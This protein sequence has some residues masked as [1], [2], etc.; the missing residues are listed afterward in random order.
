MT[1]NPIMRADIVLESKSAYPTIL[2]LKIDS[3]IPKTR[4]EG[5]ALTQK[6]KSSEASFFDILFCSVRDFKVNAPTGYPPVKDKKNAVNTGLNLF[7]IPQFDIK[8][9]IHIKGKSE[10]IKIPYDKIKPFLTPERT[11]SLSVN[12]KYI[13]M[14][15]IDITDAYLYP[16]LIL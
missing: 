4:K 13:Q 11:A 7:K 1:K 12:I 15:V 5:P 9:Q 2:S 3:P 8:L 16:C 10:G 14:N 6:S